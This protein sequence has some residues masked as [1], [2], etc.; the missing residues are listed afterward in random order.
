MK[1]FAY[2]LCIDDAQIPNLK[3][4]YDLYFVR[5]PQI[6]NEIQIDSKSNN[7]RSFKKIYT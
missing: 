2:Y 1:Q 3:G 4:L 5:E 6:A 7:Q